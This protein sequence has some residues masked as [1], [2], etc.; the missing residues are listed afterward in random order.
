M[1]FVRNFTKIQFLPILENHV[2]MT[3]LGTGVIHTTRLNQSG[4]VTVTNTIILCRRTGESTGVLWKV[5]TD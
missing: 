2:K 3:P 5:H 1:Y 4:L